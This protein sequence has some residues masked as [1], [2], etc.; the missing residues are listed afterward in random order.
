[1]VLVGIQFLRAAPWKVWML[2]NRINFPHLSSVP[3]YNLLWCYMSVAAS[4]E[5]WKQ[6]VVLRAGGPNGVI[7]DSSID[8]SPSGSPLLWHLWQGFLLPMCRTCLASIEPV[9]GSTKPRRSLDCFFCALAYATWE[10]KMPNKAP[11]WLL[12]NGTPACVRSSR[13]NCYS[14]KTY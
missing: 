2:Q 11:T 10:G 1:M 9:Q 7:F 5:K 3:L 8:Q 6:C 12:F 4:R 14:E 13:R